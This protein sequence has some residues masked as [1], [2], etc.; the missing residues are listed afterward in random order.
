MVKSKEKPG[1]QIWME[2]CIA[3]LRRKIPYSY[4]LLDCVEKEDYTRHQKTIKR[5]FE[6]QYGKPARNNLNRVLADLKQYLRVES[7][8]TPTEKDHTRESI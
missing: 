5:R 1:W 4:V 7:K 6:K 3:A 2:S 8:K